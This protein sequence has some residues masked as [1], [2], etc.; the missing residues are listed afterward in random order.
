MLAPAFS[1]TFCLRPVAGV[2]ESIW[3]HN[4]YRVA[5]DTR[6]ASKKSRRII[7]RRFGCCCRNKIPLVTATVSENSNSRERISLFDLTVQEAADDYAL[8][9][10]YVIDVLIG[11]GVE[12]PI[13][14]SDVLGK[15]VKKSKEQEVLEAISFA[16]GIEIADLY[17]QPTIAEIA[18]TNQLSCSELLY[19]LEKEGFSAPLGSRSRVPSQYSSLVH[20]QV[21][22]LL[23]RK[24]G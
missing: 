3:F 10:D 16:D 23:F 20:E 19:A 24:S 8:P 1:L 22:R 5:R 21:T 14:A 11:V 2:R 9:L 13:S 12:E 6:C 17:L 15:R 7:W 4:S 18:E